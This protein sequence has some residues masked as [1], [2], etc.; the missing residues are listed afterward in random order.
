MQAKIENSAN[1]Q[2]FCLVFPFNCF[3]L[4]SITFF[5]FKR[6][7]FKKL[8]I[9][10][11]LT[12]VV[13]IHICVIFNYFIRLH[14]QY[15][16]S[17]MDTVRDNHSQDILLRMDNDRKT[18]AKYCDFTLV[19]DG[20]RFPVHRNVLGVLSTFFDKLFHI[21]M[22]E[23]RENKVEINGVSK[24]VLEVILDFIYTGEMALSMEN[25]FAVIE[26]AHQM[27]LPYVKETCSKYLGHQVNVGNWS[28]IRAYAQRYNYKELLDKVDEA[29]ALQ[30]DA[31]VKT[32]QFIELN[33]EDLKHFL[34]L[35]KRSVKSED[36]VYKAVIG[37]IKHDLIGHEI[38]TEELLSL[39]NFSKMSVDFLKRV[40]TNEKLI[41]KS[42]A[43][44]RAVLGAITTHPGTVNQMALGSNADVLSACKFVAVNDQYAMRFTGGKTVK[45]RFQFN[46][47]GGSVAQ[48]RDFLYVVGGFETKVIEDLDLSMLIPTNYGSIKQCRY[49]SA[50]IV[51]GDHVYVTGGINA[52]S[53]SE[54]FLL[55]DQRLKRTFL[56]TPGMIV[57]RN[58]HALVHML[59]RIYVVGGN[60]DISRSFL[61]FHPNLERITTQPRMSTTRIGLAAVLFKSAL[62][63]ISGSFTHGATS[64]SVEKFDP[65]GNF[66][67]TVAS[68]NVARYRP[69]ACVI[70]H[71]LVV[72]GGG[73]SK[74]EIY[75]DIKNEWKIVGE[76]EDLKDV[77]AILPC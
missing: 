9:F 2:I 59:N 30:F 29:I 56:A 68:L 34:A 37:W 61:S 14:I 11:P 70:N 6:F 65:F 43:C 5:R 22:K 31:V 13:E 3:L 58:G 21:D 8:L 39:I 52:E 42:L 18:S 47:R 40:V 46:H 67:S 27:D 7:H 23:K 75:D 10:L 60:V 66:W 28:S 73:S 57:N 1:V 41:E 12:W 63:A 20:H 45:K 44:T 69:G 32:R 62:Y 77:F 64:S 51:V 17:N 74:I 35:E 38:Y 72:V 24:E 19:A 55:E 50:S 26:A 16:L 15:L 71:Q 25:V 48:N 33:V 4:T 76:C 53:F 36:E 49:A 54:K